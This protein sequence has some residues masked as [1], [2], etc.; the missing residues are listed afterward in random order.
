MP[1]VASRPLPGHLRRVCRRSWRSKMEPPSKIKLASPQE[2]LE[3][4]L[5][6]LGRRGTVAE[7]CRQAGV[8]REL[9]YRW[10]RLV[11]GAAL[12]ALE[13]KEPGPKALLEEEAPEEA[14]RLREVV[15]RLEGQLRAVRRERSRWKLYAETA[16]GILKR[17]AWALRPLEERK[18]NGRRRPKRGLFTFGSGLR[19]ESWEP[20]PEAWPG[21]GGYP[22]APTGGG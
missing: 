17:N 2:R 12:K 18:K 22:G 1:P 20:R 7:L 19:P 10:L 9:F 13:A 4:I 6:G 16:R 14:L 3:L 11:R 15:R 21:A 8:S 5:L